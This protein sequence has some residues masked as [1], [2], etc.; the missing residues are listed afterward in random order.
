VGGQPK[1]LGGC[2]TGK[3]NTASQGER[4]T[5]NRQSHYEGF[6]FIKKHVK[7]DIVGISVSS[8]EDKSIQRVHKNLG[9]ISVPPVKSNG[10]LLSGHN[11]CGLLSS[12]R[13]GRASRLWLSFPPL[14]PGRACVRF[15]DCFIPAFARAIAL[16]FR[17]G[18]PARRGFLST[19]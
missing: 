5:K 17:A 2:E 12:F 11:K 9:I 3:K 13:A 14:L 1:G 7:P 16:S 15:C 10:I 4:H 19:L 18:Q 8:L 6:L